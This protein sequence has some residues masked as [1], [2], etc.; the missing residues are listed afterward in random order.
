MRNESERDTTYCDFT[1]ETR[2]R[3][4]S[5]ASWDSPCLTLLEPREKKRKAL[6]RSRVETGYL[7]QVLQR[8]TLIPHR[9]VTVCVNWIL[10]KRHKGNLISVWE[11]RDIYHTYN[12]FYLA[13]CKIRCGHVATDV[14][15]IRVFMRRNKKA[16]VGYYRRNSR[17]QDR[18]ILSRLSNSI[19]R[20]Y[21]ITRE[22][23]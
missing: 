12:Y 14:N 4:R 5:H 22:N 13:R 21:T 6:F 2:A 23:M 3:I 19:K 17:Y 16:I 20:N 15:T 18:Y 1:A 11:K 7:R 10:R 9:D 8:L